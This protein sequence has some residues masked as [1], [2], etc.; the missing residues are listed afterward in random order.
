M[1]SL[2][3]PLILIIAPPAAAI[4]LRRYDTWRDI[5]A[6]WLFITLWAL[7]LLPACNM[8]LAAGTLASLAAIHPPRHAAA[9]NDIPAA[10]PYAAEINQAAHRHNLDP[11]LLAALVEVES[12]FN[13]RA[14]SHAGAMGLAQIMPATA[15]D[16]GLAN[17]FD[18][19][20]N[21]DAGAQYLAWLLDRY[22]GRLDLALAAYNAGPGRVDRCGLCIPGNH[23]YVND[24]TRLR[25][26][27]AIR[28]LI[29]AGARLTHDNRQPTP[30]K[31]T[32]YT[33][34]CGSPIP[35]PVAATVT[36][37]GRDGFVGAHGA[38]NSYII[39]TAEDMEIIY[40]HGRYTATL[41]A[42]LEA[43]ELIGYEASIG[44]ST[45]CHT[46]LSIRR[47]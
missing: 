43:G 31:G 25:D 44:N 3:L 36:G 24:V 6:A 15:A 30:F 47:K 13:P 2:F 23:G 40:L 21:L 32:D 17:A 19:A 4:W 37:L 41:G 28:S 20:A 33:T 42:R 35:A 9:A 26:Y 45:G 7:A 29:P 10:I 39:L 27:Y 34:G 22:N 1:T 16:L 38:N 14:V 18:P 8:I 12:A 5:R 11:A 46:D